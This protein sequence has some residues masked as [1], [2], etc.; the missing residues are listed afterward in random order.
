VWISFHK[1]KDEKKEPA[2]QIR[3]A[4]EQNTMRLRTI[5]PQEACPSLSPGPGL[6]SSLKSSY[7]IHKEALWSCCPAMLN[8]YDVSNN[9]NIETVNQCTKAIGAGGIFRAAIAV[10]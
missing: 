8:V 4:P 9:P 2:I 7:R 5:H 6:S 1:N 3:L 10:Y